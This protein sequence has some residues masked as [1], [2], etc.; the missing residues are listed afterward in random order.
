MISQNV[1][2]AWDLYCKKTIASIFGA[3]LHSKKSENFIKQLGV[4]SDS[5]GRRIETVNAFEKR[6][7]A[8]K[9]M[10]ISCNFDKSQWTPGEITDLRN[11]IIHLK[12]EK[13]I[14]NGRKFIIV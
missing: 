3:G 6:T 5:V 10:T 9:D 1:Q 11:S 4:H 8:I 13:R 12:H 14:E 2:D 7:T